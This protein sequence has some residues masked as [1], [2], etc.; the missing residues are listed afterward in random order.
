MDGEVSGRLLASAH[1]FARH[2]LIQYGRSRSTILI[3]CSG[4]L[5]RGLGMRAYDICI[6]LRCVSYTAGEKARPARPG[7][8]VVDATLPPPSTV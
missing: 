6:G 8:V 2:K 5:L 1:D 4:F 3:C 7:V